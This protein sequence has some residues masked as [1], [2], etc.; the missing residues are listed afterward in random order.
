MTTSINTTSAPI[1]QSDAPKE[2]S[3]IQI[4]KFCNAANLSGIELQ[5]STMNLMS[6]KMNNQ[7]QFQRDCNDQVNSATAHSDV[8]HGINVAMTVFSIAT[9]P[10]AIG[11]SCVAGPEVLGLDLAVVQGASTCVDIA[12]GA[13][14]LGLGTGLAVTQAEFG[15]DEEG[16]QTDTGAIQ[17]VG[18]QTKQL[19]DTVTN[20]LKIAQG[21]GQ[22]VG[23]LIDNTSH[24]DTAYKR[25]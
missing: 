23:T 22:M 9:I 17:N 6:N 14:S 1:A 16:I 5:S 25:K 20:I 19:G 24:A 11:L 15:Q 7:D 2:W 8:M 21:Q 3:L 4:V 13:S 10:L 18:S 12:S